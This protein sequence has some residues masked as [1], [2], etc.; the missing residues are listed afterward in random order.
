MARYFIERPVFAWVIAI[1]IMLA[2]ALTITNLPVE[3][4]PTVAPPTVAINASYPGA[5]AKTVENAVTQVIEQQLTGIDNLRYFSA[6]SQ[7]GSASLTL[8]FEPGTDADIAQVQTQN[9]VQ[10]AITRLPQEVQTQGVTVTKSNDSFLLVVGFYS[11]DGS[12]SQGQL[13]D[14]LVSNFQDPISRL[15]GVG[16]VQVFGS[17]YAMRIW[18]DPDKLVNFS[19]T[20]GDVQNAIRAQNTD[21]SAG[22]L[23]ALPAI[24]GQQINAT[25]KAQSRLQTVDDFKN[26]ILRVNTDGSQVRLSDV[27]RVELGSEFYSTISRFKGKP[28]SGMA[29]SLSTGANALETA[30]LVKAKVNELVPYLPEGVEVVF[31]FDTTPFIEKSIS[32]VVMTMIEAVGL[33][34]LVMLLFLQSFRATLIPTIAI[35][36]VLL[37]TFAIMG[38]FGY[39]I[40]VLTMFAM[41]LAIGLLVDDAIVV[42]ENVERVMEEDGLDPKEATKKSMD[43]ISGAL[44]GIG[45]VLSAVFVPMA[46]F[47]GS[48]GAIY[49]Q[50]SIT[51]VSVMGLSVLVA[52]VLSPTMCATFLK[53]KK[54]EYD[55]TKGFFGPFNRGFDWVRNKYEAGT[56]HMARRILRFA[57]IY[58][59][60]ITVMALLFTSLPK[61]FL[62]DEDQ[63]TMFVLVDTPVGASA[64]RT[65][66]SMQKIEHYLLTEQADTV[67]GFFTVVGFSFSGLAQNAGMGF[68]R[69]KDWEERPGDDLSVFAVRDQTNYAFSQL[70]DARAFAIIPP[71][72]Q[73][74]GNASGFNFQL[75][76]RGG[77]GHEALMQAR[78]QVLGAAAQNPNLVGVRPGGLSDV[79]Q[80]KINIDNEK[81]ATMGLDLSEINRTLQIAWGSSYVNDFLD[82]GKVK[83][84]YMQGE[85]SS[86]MVP[87]DLSKWY[88][89][90]NQGQ[91]IPFDR[92]ST[93]EWE[94]GSPKLERFNAVP[95]MNI[96]G[97][98]APGISSGVAMDEIEQIVNNLPGQFGIEWSGL[99]YEEQE[100]GDQTAALYAISVLIVFLSLAALYES[101]AVPLVVILAVPLGVLGTVLAAKLFGIPNDV[102]FQV[103]LLTTV[104]LASKNAILIVEF[105][106]DLKH[107]GMGIMEAVAESARQRFRPIIMTSMAF[108][109]GVSPLALSSGAGAVSQ[110]AIGIAVIG[111]ML[112]STM[113]AILFIPMFF[114]AV[115]KVFYRE[116]ITPQ[117]IG[118][119]KAIDT[120]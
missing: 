55:R 24:D 69:L 51:I 91:M 38:V 29:V 42:V 90:N 41:V 14:I 8:T 104:G 112:A 85:A 58:G 17:Q 68:I 98:P 27:A 10:G 62:P 105:A 100:S 60:I 15:K 108:I 75:V 5:S 97:Q 54:P 95:S 81:A 26:I 80:L 96:Q 23:G 118:Q 16:N 22:Q 86:R 63:G 40:N 56:S 18:L 101:W 31:P 77:E 1:I 109:L 4:Y 61:S 117:K 107:E 19:M 116:K 74:L 82:R 13:G 21:I 25:V 36:V 89:A 115:E 102:Y 47:P 33:V 73:S 30:D 66:E 3:Q 88:V 49:R 43:Q 48:S 93:M 57:V 53:P 84:V 99:S 34:F 110:N 64:E 106:Q 52:L 92:F 103:A 6:S 59:L 94:Y 20:P 120:K 76:D 44:I 79:P 70:N 111:G 2:G 87:E 37:G 11:E 65:R 46:F 113:V 32:S 67:E 119:E 39:T 7:D 71:P 45:V 9:K 72:I 28:A 114:V 78:N 83:K 35:P 50:F 12:V